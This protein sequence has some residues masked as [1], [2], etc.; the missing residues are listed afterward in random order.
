M[1][2]KVVKAGTIQA[3]DRAFQILETVGR[4]NSI[5]LGELSKMIQVNKASLSR[6]T[7]TLTQNGY[8]SKNQKDN[9]YSL[10]LKA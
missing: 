8:L 6:L 5:S 2:E 4:E 9:S 1:E 10:T 7:Y 3:V